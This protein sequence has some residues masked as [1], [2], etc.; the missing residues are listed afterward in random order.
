MKQILIYILIF[1]INLQCTAQ[2]I[3]LKIEGSNQV[4]NKTIDS[5]NYTQIHKNAKSIKE[6]INKL[7]QKLT[8]TGYIENQITENNKTNDSSFYAKIKLGVKIKSVHIYIGN[9][10]TN[11]DLNIFETKKDTIKIAFQQIETFLNENLKKLEQKGF[12]LAKLKLENIKK[13]KNILLADLIIETNNLRKLNAIILNE[14]NLNFPKGHLA[15]INRKYKNKTFNKKITK[16]IHDDFENLG[17]VRQT[18]YPEILFTKD[19]TKVY[20]YLKKSKANNFDGFIGFGNNESNKI[21]FKGYLDLTLK[22]TLKAGEQFSLFWKSDGNKQKI[23]RS[24]IEIPYL[25][26]SPIGLKAQINIFKQDTVF[27]NTKT[28]LD[29]SYFLNY[30]T[31]LYLGYQTTESSDIQNTNNNNISDFKNK[32]I[33]SKLIYL[34]T[35][36]T[37]PLFPTET[38]YTITTGTGKRNQTQNSTPTNNQY[39]I[40]LQGIHNFH[41]N[42]KNIININSQLHYLKSD[43]YLTNELI[44]F[45]GINSIRGFEE[46]SLQANFLYALSTEYRYI[47]SSNTYVHTITDYSISYDPTIIDKKD[48]NKTLLGLGI[49]MGIKTKSGLLNLSAANGSKEGQKIKFYN[50]IIQLCYNVKF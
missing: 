18:K 22:N 1:T 32:F 25:F 47:L 8:K 21:E 33:T 9:N 6:E 29:I 20:I 5:L 19:S 16:E 13:Q 12:S 35:D 31:R 43:N 37:N 50:T 14:R 45:G 42:N 17:F 39:F 46:N 27:Q 36:N 10:K 26:K 15:Q 44:R 38:S 2:N 24:N 49:G 40:N 30:N 11:E 3:R 34:K 23:F 48:N 7:A 28:E 41:L 4:E